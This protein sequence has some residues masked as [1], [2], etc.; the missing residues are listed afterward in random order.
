[1]EAM[2]AGKPVVATA[3]GGGPAVVADGETGILVQPSDPEALAGAI[4][5]LLASSQLRQ[6]M[7][8]RGS[9]RASQLFDVR[10]MLE[11]TK[12]VY[13]DVVREMMHTKGDVL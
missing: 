10:L 8:E 9:Q 6:Q 12:Q 13:S 3:V 5:Q 2:S 4:D 11:R 7:G 1:M